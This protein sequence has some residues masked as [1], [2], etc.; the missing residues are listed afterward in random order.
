[1]CADN[2]SLDMLHTVSI[3][4][5]C[6]LP[7]LFLAV[8]NIVFNLQGLVGLFL[9]IFFVGWSAWISTR[10]FERLTHMTHQKW[11]ILYPVALFYACFALI[12]VF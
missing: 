8:I 2:A 5:Y 1:M 7:I 4:G 10:F 11:L 3:V 6:V 12:T 9:T